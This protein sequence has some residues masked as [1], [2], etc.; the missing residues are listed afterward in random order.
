M[1]NQNENSFKII[2]HGEMKWEAIIL[3]LF[4]FKHVCKITLLTKKYQNMNST[5]QL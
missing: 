3:K 2:M 1:K 4:K 5:C